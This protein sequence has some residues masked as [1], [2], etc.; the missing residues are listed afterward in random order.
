MV[1][2]GLLGASKSPK[3]QKKPVSRMK[4]EKSDVIF[5]LPQEFRQMVAKKDIES[6]ILVQTSPVIP[7]E[8]F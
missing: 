2:S 3:A 1:F 4:M 5:R 7:L 6:Q 8:V